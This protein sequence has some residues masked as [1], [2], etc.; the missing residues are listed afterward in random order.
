MQSSLARRHDQN[1]R[2]RPGI[3]FD[4]AERLDKTYAN[5]A[6]LAHQKAAL[7]AF[8]MKSVGR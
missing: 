7:K 1:A 3:G 5:L 8:R 4:E 6:I 2:Q